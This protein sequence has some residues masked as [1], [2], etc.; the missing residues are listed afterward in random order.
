MSEQNPTVS[1]APV[2]PAKPSKPS[3]PSPEFPL[4]AHPAGHWCKKIRGKIHYFGRWDDPD[5]AL[6]KYLETKDALHAGKTPRPDAGA[7]TIKDVANHFLN[8]NLEHQDSGQLSP[9]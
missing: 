4:T 2:K 7:L 3:K 5:A 8:T 9:R 1:T 6:Q